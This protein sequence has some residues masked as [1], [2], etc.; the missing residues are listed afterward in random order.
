MR[1][2]VNIFEKTFN[3][4]DEFARQAS[5]YSRALNTEDWKFLVNAIQLI[6]QQMSFD[7]FSREFTEMSESEKDVLQKT[8]YQTMLIL[9][10]LGNPNRWINRKTELKQRLAD[11]SK[12]NKSSNTGGKTW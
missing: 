4:N 11:L 8:Y 3:N 12:K 10:F 6:K 7:M 5:N 1:N 2:L 9:D